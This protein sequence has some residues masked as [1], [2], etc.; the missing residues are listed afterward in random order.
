MEGNHYFPPSDVAFEFL[1]ESRSSTHC[2]WKG[3]ASYYTVVVEGE[4]NKDAAWFY[5]APYDAASMIKDHI[6]FWKGVQIS[7]ANPGEP[8]IS[9]P[10]R[11]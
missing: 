11:Y 3:E 2:T 5:A 8:E 9:A 7:G 10:N 1:E 6:A 4:R